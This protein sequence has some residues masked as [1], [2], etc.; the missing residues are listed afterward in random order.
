[1]IQQVGLIFVFAG[2]LGVLFMR[3]KQPLI[4]AYV[5]AGVLVGP[6]FLGLA[7]RADIAVQLSEIA[8]VVMLFIIG[9]EMDIDRLI[10]VG[11]VAIL[12]CIAQV[13]LIFVLGFFLAKYFD[14][15]N[16]AACY[17]GFGAAFS[18][19]MLVVK[20]LG[21]KHDMDTLYGR[22]SVGMLIMQDI[23]AIFAL[24]IVSSVGN[25]SIG[26]VLNTLTLTAGLILIV[27]F[28]LGRLVFPFLFNYIAREREVLF[29][30][31][32]AVLFGMGFYAE[33]QM[34]SLGIGSFLAGLSLASLSYRYE[35]IGDFK[36]LKT[37]FIILFFAALGLQL[38]PQSLFN[39]DMDIYSRM[40]A[41]GKAT[42]RYGWMIIGF[43]LLV[44]VVKPI[45]TTVIVGIFGYKKSTAF[46]V[47][48]SL[49]QFSEFSLVL[50]AQGIAAGHVKP[51][52]LPAVIIMTVVS[53]TLSSYFMKFNLF[54]YQHMSSLLGWLD[55]IAIFEGN[56][57]EERANPKNDFKVLLVGCDRIGCIIERSL[58]QKG[59]HY[60]V[61]DSNP[62]VIAR[63]VKLG[64]PCIFGDVNNHEVL[65]AIDFG[66][67]EIVI[68][69]VPDINDN[70]VLLR[71]VDGV[72]PN[73]N[74]VGIVDS[75][76]QAERLY[77]LG[78]HFVLVNYVLAGTQLLHSRQGGLHSLLE[79]PD[80]IRNKG[81]EHRKILA[82]GDILKAC[83]FDQEEER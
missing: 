8:I 63:L 36:A 29:V 33:N 20:I 26:T 40:I 14:Q 43:S 30:F 56:K 77:S 27:V 72:N 9:I 6:L 25:F 35:I 21:E 78:A 38:A 4:P 81:I 2:L 15:S 76:G 80:G 71:H 45:I 49:G 60:V 52:V 13:G 83:S 11:L 70:E 7:N 79:T 42:A 16:M 54:F 34:L 37:F 73:I 50:L 66:K 75:R 59:V 12:G 62:E 1:M 39:G 57:V 32:M 47:G 31:S 23:L 68:S 48:L 28:I 5:L 22:I 19:T 10:K 82:A 58:H 53:M 41:F 64:I 17:F 65:A 74:F 55:K 67:I 51:A 46:N 69:T 61:V 44:I 18:S 24:S 3:L